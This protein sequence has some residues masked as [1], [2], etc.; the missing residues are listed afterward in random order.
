[1]CLDLPPLLVRDVAMTF[2]V[3]FDLISLFDVVCVCVAVFYRAL[4]EGE[5]PSVRRGDGCESG[6]GQILT[7]EPLHDPV[8]HS[9]KDL[10]EV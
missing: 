9:N 8:H 1:M 6:K 5:M 3:T 10:T 2:H 7:A 4:L